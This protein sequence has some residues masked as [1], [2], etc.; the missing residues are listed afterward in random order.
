MCFVRS[1]LFQN[2]LVVCGLVLLSHGKQG[3]PI[4]GHLAVHIAQLRAMY[5]EHLTFSFES[6]VR[7][8]RQVDWQKS[9]NG[10]NLSEPVTVV[11]PAAEPLVCFRSGSTHQLLGD[12]WA[13]RD[14]FWSN[15]DRVRSSGLTGCCAPA[16]QL[17]AL[18][19]VG[20]GDIRVL[21]VVP[22]DKASGAGSITLFSVPRKG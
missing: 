21:G 3:V 9:V 5:S 19:M 17:L 16:D 4:G 22:G 7:G 18:V 6:S 15:T 14:R 11:L 10:L 8:D 13:S 2:T 12:V 1:D 20:C